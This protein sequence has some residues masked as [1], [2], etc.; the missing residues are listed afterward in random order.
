MTLKKLITIVVLLSLPL[1]SWGADLFVGDKAGNFTLKSNQGENLRLS[2]QRGQVILMTF[3]GSWCGQ[4]KQQLKGLESLF[5]QYKDKGFQVWAV[6]QDEDPE[7]AAYNARQSGVS[8]PVLFDTEH[9][10]AKSYKID[11]LPTVVIADRDGTIRY[12]NEK[13]KNK[14]LEQYQEQVNKLVNE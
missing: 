9:R 12:V 11:D 6:S 8:Y 13:H 1:F 5:L 3:W 7:K 4:C 10:V 14:Y 2:E